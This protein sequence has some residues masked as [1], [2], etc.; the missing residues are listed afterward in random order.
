MGE[1][2]PGKVGGVDRCL[3]YSW[4]LDEIDLPCEARRETWGDRSIVESWFSP[5][6]LPTRR[7]FDRFPYHSS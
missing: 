4:S 6:K 3:W 7:F 5:F 2:I 1:L